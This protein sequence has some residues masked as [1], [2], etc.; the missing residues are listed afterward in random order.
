MQH[1]Q[2][3]VLGP[4]VVAPLRHAMRLVDGE[5]RKLRACEQVERAIE[6]QAFGRDVQQIQFAAQQLLFDGARR[7]GIERGV[8]EGGA[9]P[10]LLERGDLVLHECDQRRDDDPGTGAHDGRNLETQ[11]LAA[12]GGHEHQRVATRQ[13]RANDFFL[14]RAELFVAE[15]AV[16]DFEGVVVHPNAH[17]SAPWLETQAAAGGM[18]NAGK[19][20]TVSVRGTLYSGVLSRRALTLCPLPKGEGKLV[21]IYFM[22]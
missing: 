15:N 4:E 8:K 20:V 14:R 5:Q 13:Q 16:Q 10:D 12:A 11:R 6:H 3:H 1:R 19:S 18:L 2:L 22:V 17:G 21:K 7:V 9:H